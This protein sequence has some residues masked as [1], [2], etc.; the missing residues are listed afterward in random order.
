MDM[1]VECTV[2]DREC[3]A[4]YGHVRRMHRTRQRVWCLVRTCSSNALYKTESVVL[5]MDMFVECTGTR[6]KL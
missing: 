4:W 3:G 2:Q 6:T 5:G 1:F